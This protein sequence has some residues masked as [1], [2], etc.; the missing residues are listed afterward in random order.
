MLLILEGA[1]LEDLIRI[2]THSCSEQHGLREAFYN[3]NA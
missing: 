2:D 3:R 1:F